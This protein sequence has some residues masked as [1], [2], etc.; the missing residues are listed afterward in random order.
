MSRTFR[1]FTTVLALGA[2]GLTS[3]ESV[4][5]RTSSKSSESK[6][7]TTA[8]Y[9][10]SE[11]GAKATPASAPRKST[12]QP[13]MAMASMAFPTGDP[14]T[15]A[16]AVEK[17]V[18]R[19][20]Q[21]GQSFEVETVVTNL[22]GQSVDDVVLTES[23]NPNLVIED[24]SVKTEKGQGVNHWR[25][26]SIGPNESKSVRL[27]AKASKP[28]RI[29][30]CVSVSYNTALCTSIP[31]VQPALK[32]VASGPSEVLACDDITYKYVVTNTGSGDA[33]DI[34]VSANL[35][36]GLTDMKGNSS[37]RFNAGTLASGKSKEFLVK[38]KATT[39]GKLTHTA[40][41]A[42]SGGL[43]AEASALTTSVV[44][45][46]LKI[47]KTGSKRSF[48]GKDLK[49]EITVTNIGDGVARETVLEDAV[50]AGTTLK[51][52]SDNGRLAS[53]K[54][55]WSLGD[56]KPKESKKIEV[57]FAN[58]RIGT[59]TNTAMANA[60]CADPVSARVT[61]EVTGIPAVLLEVID[62]ED[63]I[64]VG[65]NSTYVITVTNQGSAPD[66]NI[67]IELG[68]PPNTEL[69]SATGATRPTT[70]APMGNKLTFT[71]LAT[72]APKAEATWRVVL[73]GVTSADARFKV[74]MNTDELTSPVEE[75]EATNYYE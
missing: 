62:L 49:Y 65:T 27:R 18:P 21:M 67:S 58:D 22:T 26:G 30:T 20:V 35:P 48:A 9:D 60:F 73:K 11:G 29:D 53:G 46:K 14:N 4:G 45:P 34:V 28:E 16:L 52:A 42:G 19:E 36:S 61:T 50:P 70:A 51:S 71:P 66:T 39:M 74:T 59:V 5:T 17:F 75:T 32:L 57:R 7:T 63:P 31:V 13:N 23:L 56:L 72:L 12:S 6:A 2:L 54:V 64:E 55:R 41:A 47:E 43:S 8:S 24:A 15:S 33:R 3:C 25:L 10:R 44:K 1:L 38:A 69:V 40:T 37:L 68:L